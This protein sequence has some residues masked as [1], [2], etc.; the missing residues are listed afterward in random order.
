MKSE[1]ISLCERIGVVSPE[2][3]WGE[4]CAHYSE[5]DR[6][7][8][9]L[10]HVKAM[11]KKF[12]LHRDRFENPDEVE[13]AI[14]MHDIIYDTKRPD[15]EQQSAYLAQQW[16]SG[17]Q[18]NTP[19]VVRLICATTHNQIHDS[20]DVNL[21]LDIDVQILAAEADLYD[22]YAGAIRQEYQWVPLP[23][24]RKERAKILMMFLNKATLFVTD[25]CG[26]SANKIARENISR[27][28]SSL[29]S[30]L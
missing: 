30:D 12:S 23:I 13:F 1:W 28:I 17:S 8:H 11:H 2:E 21:L 10:D 25:I 16:A 26:E 14:F 22:W 3:K 9:T 27:E 5:V 15:N 19:L 4:L 18:L 7:Y 29:T 20:S 6:V 24:Y